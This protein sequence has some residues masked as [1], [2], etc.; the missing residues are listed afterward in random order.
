[1]V[2]FLER[3]NA[4]VECVGP[5]GEVKK[6][7]LA[8]MDSLGLAFGGEKKETACLLQSWHQKPAGA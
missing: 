8:D 1:M 5:T 4:E 3:S 7:A 6:G 2:S